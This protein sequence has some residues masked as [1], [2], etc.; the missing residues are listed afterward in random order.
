MNQYRRWRLI[1]I[2]SFLFN[3][4]F[5]SIQFDCYVLSVNSFPMGYGLALLI[6]I[7]NANIRHTVCRCRHDEH[8]ELDFLTKINC[9]FQL[10]V[11]CIIKGASV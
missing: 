9:N 5:P 4:R 8:N 11:C 10:F 2:R 3:F 6:F 1:S 7:D